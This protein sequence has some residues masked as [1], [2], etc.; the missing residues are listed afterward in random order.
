MANYTYGTLP[1]GTTTF[2]TPVAGT[3]DVITATALFDF[4]IG[5]NGGND[6]VRTGD[7]NDSITTGAGN[8]AIDAANG[9]NTINAGNGINT[10]TTGSGDDTISSGTGNDKIEAGNGNNTVTA[11]DGTNTVTTGSGNDTIT[12]GAGADVIN[13]GA[14]N[15]IIIAGAGDDRIN[16]GAGN[17]KVN[18]GVGNDLVTPGGGTDSL[19][20]GG[21]HDT[22]I[23]GS[24]ADAVLGADTI[25]DFNIARPSG[26]GEGDMINL[27]G[28]VHDF[29]GARSS[30]LVDLVAHGYLHFSAGGGGTVLSYDS[31]GNA[32]GGTIGVLV[33]LVG[34]GFTTEGAAV[35]DFADNITT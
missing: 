16:S 28:L 26:A 21:G 8:D 35:H 18:A 10:V 6:I 2:T 30:S 19:T 25:A 34:V 31:N 24:L 1:F 14:G 9:N 12:T 29:N 7:G 32:A 15:D 11:G 17:D 3:D 20:G 33:T 23:F 4:T 5:G 13:S 22:F 27:A